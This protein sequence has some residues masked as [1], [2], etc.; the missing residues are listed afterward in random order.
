MPRVQSFVIGFTTK[1]RTSFIARQ[2]SQA[3][4]C[5]ISN[6]LAGKKSTPSSVISQEEALD[7]LGARS[8]RRLLWDDLTPS[9]LSRTIKSQ[10]SGGEGQVT[11]QQSF[12]T[13]KQ[14]FERASQMVTSNPNGTQHVPIFVEAANHFR[15][16]STGHP[17]SSLAEDALFLEGESFFFSDRYVQA[18][19]ISIPRPR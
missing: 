4:R 7:P 11:A 15:A 10:F 2:G 19:W 14:L 18:R 9:Q 12:A 6:G 16:A 8:H 13:G 5:K 1:K 17:D 3:C